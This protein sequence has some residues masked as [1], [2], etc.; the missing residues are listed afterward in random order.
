MKFD[1]S[2]DDA[3]EFAVD[4]F[5][6]VRDKDDQPYVLHLLRVMH[7]CQSDDAKIVA[8]LHDIVED[9]EVSLSMLQNLGFA[10]RIVDA[11]AC[12]THHNSETYEDYVVGLSTDPIA[13]ECKIADLKDNYRIERVA[14]REG[15]EHEDL[16]R[17]QRYILSY[18]FLTKSIGVA[19][20]RRRMERSRLDAVEA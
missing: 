12:L 17:L 6:G 10:E 5:R 9:T 18:R 19:E 8:L 20:Y 15:A 1:G 7:Q 3:I 14:F 11:I 16:A 2:L 4:R 13:V